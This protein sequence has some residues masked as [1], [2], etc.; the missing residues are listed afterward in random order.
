M[1]FTQWMY[2]NESVSTEKFMYILPISFTTVHY[3]ITAIS[4]DTFCRVPC[5]WSKT[6]DTYHMKTFHFQGNGTITLDEASY[7]QAIMVGY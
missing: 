1:I 7:A 4:M 2:T 5:V 6:I 3:V